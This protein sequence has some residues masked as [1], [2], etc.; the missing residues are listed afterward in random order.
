MIYPIP[1]REKYF[2]DTYRPQEKYAFRDLYGFYRE[3]KD[4]SRDIAFSPDAALAPEEYILQ[5]DGSGIRIAH[6]TEEGKFRA[7][8][9]LRQLLLK[10][11]SALPYAEIRDKPDFP[12]RAFMLEIS[13]GRMPKVPLLCEIIDYI[14]GLKYNEFQLYM[15]N[16][17]FKYSAFPEAN[18]ASRTLS[19]RE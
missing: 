6:S 9:S 13:S 3:T 16:F 12:A 11:S 4:G 2:E 8:T 18:T 5:I 17:C 19:V 15:E 1:H 10:H 14:A 7:L